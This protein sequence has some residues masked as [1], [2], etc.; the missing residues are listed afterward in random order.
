MEDHIFRRK[1][2]AESITKSGSSKIVLTNHHFINR[3]AKAPNSDVAGGSRQ[4][5]S[6]KVFSH[7]T[8]GH[9]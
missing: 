7:L 4:P 3:E 9:L 6:A 8:R 5:E 2:V 1:R